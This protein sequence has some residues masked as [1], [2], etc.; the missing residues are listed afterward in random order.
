MNKNCEEFKELYEQV[1]KMGWIPSHRKGNTGIGKTFEDLIH[2][3]EDNLA[4]PDF[5]NIEIK[6]QRNASSSMITLFTKSP[7]YPKKV[8]SFLRENFGNFSK[9]YDGKKIL[10]TT[11]STKHFNTHVSGN[12][13]KILIDKDNRRLV[14]Q[15]RKHE[16]QEIIYE[17]AY[18]SFE[19]LEKA[20]IKK[21]KFI[22]VIGADE[23]V[24]NSVNYFLYNKLQLITGLTFENFLNALENGDIFVDIRIGVYNTGKNIGKTHDHGTGFRIKLD[25][26]LKYATIIEE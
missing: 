26:L 5:K 1:K 18:W 24:E 3:K 8:N 22:A 17:N 4:L 11:V 13:F 23:K 20:L 16:T 21:L 15:V 14:L 25:T 19:N 10:H 12:D 2:K 7:D 9:E 6:S